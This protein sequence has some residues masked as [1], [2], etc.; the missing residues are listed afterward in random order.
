MYI[1]NCTAKAYNNITITTRERMQTLCATK[2]APRLLE[3]NKTQ[4][5]TKTTRYYVALGRKL[6]RRSINIAFVVRKHPSG[7][8]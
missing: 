6:D 3:G 7:R 5:T 8:A 1:T 2:T 4:K